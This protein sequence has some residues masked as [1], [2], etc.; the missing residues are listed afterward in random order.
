MQCVVPSFLLPIIIG[1]SLYAGINAEGMGNL[2]EIQK[3]LADIMVTPIGMAGCTAIIMFFFMLNYI[4]VTS[5][6]RDG[7]NAVFMKYIPI[8]F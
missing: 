8:N 4:S 3:Q 5:I 7:E 1:M 6:S 2:S